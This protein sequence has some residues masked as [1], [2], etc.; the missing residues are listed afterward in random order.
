MARPY[1][2][3][4]D[5][6]EGGAIIKSLY[7]CPTRGCW[8]MMEKPNKTCDDCRDPKVRK[9][10]TDEWDAHQK[11]INSPKVEIKT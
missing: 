8:N 7:I 10:I 11:A 4:P 5:Q 1:V 9:Q 6:D 2:K 3:P